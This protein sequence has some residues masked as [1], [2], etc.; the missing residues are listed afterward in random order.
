MFTCPTCKKRKRKPSAIVLGA[1]C[2]A[3]NESDSS[4]VMLSDRQS[5]RLAPFL[6]LTYKPDASGPETTGTRRKIVLAD[7]V[8]Q[9]IGSGQGEIQFCGFQCFRRFFRDL[10]RAIRRHSTSPR[11]RKRRPNEYE[12]IAFPESKPH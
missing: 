11:S 5:K 12:I 7:V 8:F 10:E 9:L 3:Q 2:M 4:T 6:S 1:G